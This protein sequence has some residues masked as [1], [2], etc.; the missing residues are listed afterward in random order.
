M[1]AFSSNLQ[2]YISCVVQKAGGVLL[3]VDSILKLVDVGVQKL[4]QLDALVAEVLREDLKDRKIEV[5]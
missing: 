1:Y 3:V 2:S 5:R 4:K